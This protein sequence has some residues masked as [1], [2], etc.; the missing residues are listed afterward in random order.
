MYRG[1]FDVVNGRMIAMGIKD[2]KSLISESSAALRSGGFLQLQEWDFF[3]VDAQKQVI[4]TDCW[5]G[6]WCAAL[7][8]SL[9]IRNAS[10]NAAEGLDNMIRSN[11][12]FHDIQQQDVWMP[13]GPFLSEDTAEGRHLNLVGEFMRE[14]VK[15]FINGG[16]TLIL[17]SG[18]NP[19]E[20]N[21][22]EF[23]ATLEVQ[24]ENIPMYLRLNCVT[25]RKL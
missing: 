23:N 22:M 15:A 5:F 7:R 16:K 24:D 6:R 3:I 20:Y 8:Q 4:G 17:G 21:K 12:T 14:N 1:Q 13:V 10:V 11:G 19:E 18:M 2:Y 25:A 9:A